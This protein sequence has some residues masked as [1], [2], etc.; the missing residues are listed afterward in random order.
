VVL[1]DDDRLLELFERLSLEA[2]RRIMEVRAQG[3]AREVKS[4]RSPVTEA[5]RAAED[6]IL[7]GLREALPGILCVAEEE[8]AAGA[9]CETGGD[10]FIL[11]DP[12]DGTREFVAGN[13]DFTVNIALVRDGAPVI[14]TVFAPAPGARF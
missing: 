6:I 7:S 2:G 5:D 4:D 13:A 10:A 14:G 3:F 11:V 9:R 12:L 8:V 1:D